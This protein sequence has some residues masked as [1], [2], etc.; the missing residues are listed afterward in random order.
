LF[1]IAGF[2]LQPYDIVQGAQSPVHPRVFVIGA[3]DSRITF[4]SQQV[5][6]LALVHALRDL[7]ILQDSQR[8]AVVGAGAA[9]VS[10]AAA[11][12]LLST[13]TV[14]L[15]ERADDIMP[16]QRA[17]RRRRLDPHIYAWP[18]IGSDDPAAELPI[19]DWTAGP[20]EEVR[21]DVKLEFEV[22]KAACPNRIRVHLRHEVTGA[23][24]AA[25]DL[26]L[27]FRRD[28]SA[29]E[30]GDGPD[31]R[32]SLQATFDLVLLAFGFGLEPR[33]PIMG[34]PSAS[35]WS[36]AGVPVAEFEGRAAP[37]FLISGNG[38]GGLID[39]VAAAS[40][41]FD[42][43]G[44][45]R[46]IVGQPGIETLFDRL[47]AIDARAQAAFNTGNGF[48][49]LGTY[50]AEIR[51]DLQALGLFELI[52]NRLRPG[53]RLTLQT[54]RP[55][56]FTIETATLNR[57][58]AYLVVRAC[59]ARTQTGFTHVHGAD[60]TLT[61]PPADPPYNVDFWFQ[62]GGHS[63]G[64]DAAIIRHGPG[65][66]AA[67]QPFE[68]LLGDYAATHKAWLG[69]HGETVRVPEL[70]PAANEALLS[71]ARVVQLPPPLYQQRQ[72][73]QQQPQRVRVQP[74][75]AGLRWSGDLA[76][77]AVAGLWDDTAKAVNI[78]TPTGP[79]SLGP[80]AAALVR[81]ALH[82]GRAT[83]V[84]NAADWLP[85]VLPLTTGSPHAEHVAPPPIQARAFAGA[86][87][88]PE[89]ASAGELALV[90][91]QALNKWVL[92]A[93]DR[94]IRDFVG[95]GRDP[96]H[97][98]GFRAAQDLRVR[99]MQVWAGWRAQLAAD[100]ELLDRLLRL[101]VSAEDKDEDQDEARVL[102]GPRKLDLLVRAVAAALAI[103]SAWP[104]TVPLGQ[105][106][107]NLLRTLAQGAVRRGHV[108]A[109]ERIEREPTA[110]AA[111][112]FMWRTHF[113]VLSQ[114]A[115]PI[116]V[117]T[118]AEAG[119]ADVDQRQPGLADR[120]GSG[121]LIL[122]LDAAFRSAARVG[123]VALTALLDETEAQHFK[124]LAAAIV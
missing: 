87:Q 78:L 68:L 83:F 108:C 65:R 76:P 44:M 70:S 40:D 4:Y 98:V 51:A 13:A 61:A 28:P 107:G 113:V 22:L 77:S 30:A 9:G 48:D 71:A 115:T 42:H 75:G 66:A 95:T 123:L 14:D 112:A 97:R 33:Q 26:Q 32:V 12:A 18:A 36:D 74:R 43:A 64:A 11:V 57:L 55:E 46:M 8:V 23:R 101:M 10:A 41:H 34:M 62:C 63:I 1:S 106:P 53:V 24:V 120:S 85:F 104:D 94:I 122:T 117:S 92:D 102:V 17:T 6:A 100:P 5:R 110:I 7:A 59:E 114:L 15:Y 109:A 56:A 69:L 16:L 50:D 124:R 81:L 119:M 27:D 31:N 67:R 49:F 105:R 91:H 93:V 121:G 89:E 2:V 38:D 25:A 52:A 47:D 86:A 35:Y 111:A 72:L 82:A 103:A 99:M 90:V 60:L 88:N 73:Q 37:R 39:L 58:A 19:L 79:D 54:L 80:L 96:G 45:I 21:G 118:Q 29:G 20:A 84:A 3:F 116:S